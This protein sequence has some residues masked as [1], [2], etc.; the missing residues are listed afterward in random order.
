MTFSAGRFEAASYDAAL[1]AY[2]TDV[3]RPQADGGSGAVVP[4][5]AVDRA[6]GRFLHDLALRVRPTLSIEVGLCQGASALHLAAAHAITGIGLHYAIDP[7]QRP[8]F[9]D[10]GLLTIE[11]F[12]LMP[13]F[14]HIDERSDRA[15][16]SLQMSGARAE[17]IFIDG[18]HRF[19]AVFHDYYWADK[20]LDI[21]GLLIFDEA[22]YD[23]PTRRVASFI[24]R[25]MPNYEAIEGPARFYVFR[26]IAED[27]RDFA[28]QA[29][30]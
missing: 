5:W 1:E 11:R 2:Y 12:G 19:D 20:I 30:F 10:Q 17:L 18:D 23:C 3:E 29:D 24:T 6:S 4:E 14:R 21:G 9:H 13:W 15:L 7:F 8:F 25:N 22:G 27:R 26:K 16:A 28:D